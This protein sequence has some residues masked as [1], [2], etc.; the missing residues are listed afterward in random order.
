MLQF[1]LVLGCGRREGDFSRDLE[2]QVNKPTTRPCIS[3]NA[4]KN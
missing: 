1:D 3:H 2:N 4:F